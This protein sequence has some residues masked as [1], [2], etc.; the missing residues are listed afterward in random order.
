M[1]SVPI[2][3][4]KA[5]CLGLVE[6]VRRTREPLE[7]TKR[8]KIVAVVNPPSV[9]AIDWSPGRCAGSVTFVGDVESPV[10]EEDEFDLDKQWF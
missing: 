5:K 4:F 10:I 1:K 8:G 6:E 2:S 7:I 3:T 9:V